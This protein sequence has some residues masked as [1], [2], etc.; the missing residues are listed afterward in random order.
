[1]TDEYEEY[2]E[3]DRRRGSIPAR[4]KVIMVLVAVITAIAIWLVPV[5]EKPSPPPLP[6]L[7]SAPDTSVELP[8]PPVQGKT[9]GLPL[10]TV[11]DKS[12]E[13]PQPSST[14]GIAAVINGGDRAR[15]F[16]AELQTAGSQPDADAAFAEAERMQGDGRLEDAYLLYRF[17]ARHGQPQAAL[18]LGTRAD[19]AFHA[20]EAGY[21]P[22]PAPGQAY[23]WYSMAATA[24]NEEAAQRL[25]ALH[26]RVQQDA[27]DGDEQARRLLLQWR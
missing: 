2:E 15:T 13:S 6:A 5:E 3:T 14:G 12:G 21:L 8:L 7:P 26:K 16:I 9:G 10:P 19:P 25:Q 23:K 24:G 22:E 20:T 1:M 18:I 17:A 11:P 27:E 4:A